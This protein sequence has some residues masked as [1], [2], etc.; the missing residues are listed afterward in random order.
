MSVSCSRPPSTENRCTETK[1]CHTI[2]DTQYVSFSYN[3]GYKERYLLYTWDMGPALSTPPQY[4]VT[5][6]LRRNNIHM[7]KLKF[8]DTIKRKFH[9]EYL[10]SPQ[11]FTAMLT[12]CCMRHGHHTNGHESGICCIRAH[13][14]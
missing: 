9:T 10:N 12:H 6:T 1:R 11:N 5:N 3:T 8:P 7:N 14:P 4:T 13:M 2:C